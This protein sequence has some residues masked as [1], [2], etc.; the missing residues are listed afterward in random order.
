MF[1]RCSPLMF[2]AIALFL[3]GVCPHSASGAE[4]SADDVLSGAGVRRGLLVHVG[5]GDG[6]LAIAVAKAEPMVVLAVTT[7]EAAAQ[8]VRGKLVAAG[9]HGQA[10]AAALDAGRIPL[11]DDL[12]AVVVC[13]LDAKP[14]VTREEFL[15]VPRPQGSAWLRQG[16]EWQKVEKPRP[17]DIDDWGQY[18]HD[19]SLSNVSGDRKAGPA[20]GLQW[21]SG[22]QVGG[23]SANGVRVAGDVMVQSD[24]SKATDGG[25]PALIARDAWSGLPLW[26]R[27]DMV[28]ATRYALLADRD[29]VY[30]C[31]VEQENRPPAPCLVA[32]DAHTGKTVMEYR[33]GLT[34]AA[35]ATKPVVP[36]SSPPGQ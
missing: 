9:V 15:R 6:S 7:D 14:G 1:L 32:L 2:S 27:A 18:H 26:R 30:V 5:A 10:T 21:L 24:G 11:A 33:E 28:P 17:S 29:R 31:P 12:A 25:E 20:Y 34:F 23:E 22:P 19:A 8:A 35:P 13:D 16:G 4:P 36:A 3:S